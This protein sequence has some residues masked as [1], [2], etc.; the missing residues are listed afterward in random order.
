[1]T[2]RRQCKHCPWKKGVNPF[3]IPGEYDPEKH[4]GLENTIATGAEV[5][6]SPLRLMACHESPVG[7]E[8]PCVGWLVNQLGP[9]NNLGLRL[10][11]MSG[12]IDANVK[13]VGPQHETFEQ[14]LPSTKV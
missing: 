14:T 5:L 1:V 9:G 8:K 6:G 7:D 3:D 2:P 13:T 10:K 12:K 4:K 11:V